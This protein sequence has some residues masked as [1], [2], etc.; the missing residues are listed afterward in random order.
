MIKV[1]FICR[2]EIQVKIYTARLQRKTGAAVCQ[3]QDFQIRR[4]LLYEPFIHEKGFRIFVNDDITAVFG[5]IFKMIMDEK[6]GVY[7]GFTDN[8]VLESCFFHGFQHVVVGT[9]KQT[10]Q[11]RGED[12]Y[13]IPG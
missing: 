8:L 13:I 11:I 4:L 10:D 6:P 5:Q 3:I 2:K 12:L 7:I 1:V 9:L